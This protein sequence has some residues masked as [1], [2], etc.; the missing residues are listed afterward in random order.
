MGAW[1]IYSKM[2]QF[3]REWSDKIIMAEN[4]TSLEEN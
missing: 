1:L 3:L 2:K 4:Y